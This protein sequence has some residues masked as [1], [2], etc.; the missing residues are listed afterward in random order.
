MKSRLK[1]MMVRFTNMLIKMKKMKVRIPMIAPKQQR[2]L[3][4]SLSPR[5]RVRRP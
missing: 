2:N 1:V 4:R 5:Y 3:Q